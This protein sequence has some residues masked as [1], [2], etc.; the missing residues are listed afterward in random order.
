MAGARKD[1]AGPAAPASAS[2]L[3]LLQV[4]ARAL[5]FVLNQLLVRLVSPSIFGLANIQLELLLSTILFLSR[6]GFRTILI[7][8][9][10]VG[11]KSAADAR[12]GPRRGV[13][14]SLHNITLLPIPIGFVLTVA[15]CTA[16]VHYISPDAMH[17]VPTFH[18]SIALYALGAL[19]ELAYEPLLIR[20]VRL[21]HPA[22]R[23]KAEGAAVFV[24]VI[25]TIATIVVLPRW[26][27]APLRIHRYLVDERAVALLAFGIGQAGFGLTMLSVHLGFF[28]SR[29]GVA[30]TLDLYVPRRERVARTDTAAKQQTQTV[31]FD[32]STLSLCATMSQQGVLKH[33]LTE[34][35][36]VAVARYATLED[37]GG[38]ALASNYGSLVARILFQP[39]EETSRIVFASELAALD[40]DE[41]A[42]ARTVDTASL[43]RVGEMVGGLL[44]LHVLLAG[45]L[46]A[47]GAPLSVAFL[48]VMAGPR[49]ALQTSAPPILGAYTF[50]LPIMGV[51]GIVEGFVQSVAGQR[52]VA[53][54]SRVLLAASAGFVASLAGLHALTARSEAASALVGKTALVWANALSASVRAAWCWAFLIHYFRLAARKA[55][56]ADADAVAPRAALPSRATLAV[57]AAVAAVLRAVVPR[58][59]PSSERLLVSGAGRVHALRLLLPT[60]ALGAACLGAVLGAIVLFERTPLVRALQSLGRRGQAE[61]RKSQ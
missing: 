17:A 31:W 25:S 26:S 1:A 10:P 16:Y 52:Q 38:Y 11:A 19:S 51:N 21:G 35:D 14:N 43:R 34:A 12:T 50:Y 47:F 27:A 58:M 39:V 30:D 5:T 3:I 32:R 61:G 23:V 6:D 4:S 53:R 24:K 29:Y 18:A 60:L 2:T 37:Q 40:P 8:N 56:S 7:R 13:P 57:F 49:W 15:A 9:E 28:C 33:C 59:M 22:L 41:P 20:A 55:S 46:T 45:V 44:R 48:Y 36:K 54:Y 42:A